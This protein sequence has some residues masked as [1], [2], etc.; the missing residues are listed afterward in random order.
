MQENISDSVKYIGVD[1]TAIELFESQY[2]VPDGMCYNSYVILDEKIAIMDTVDDVA[3]EEWMQNLESAIGTRTPDYVVVSHMEPDHAAGLG[4]LIGKFPAMKVVGN[5]KTFTMI[6]QFFECDLTDRMVVV[7]EGDILDLGEHKLRFVMAP[8]IHWPEV[9]VAYDETDKTLYSADAFGKFGTA[10]SDKDDWICE[11]RRYYF[12]IVGKYGANVQMLLKKLSGVEVK[13]IAPLHG[14]ILRDNIG[15][16]VEMYDLW[17]RYQP[18]DKGV[19]MIAYASIHGNTKAAAYKMQEALLAEGIEEV[20]MFDLTVGD[21][22]F[23]VEDA[24]QCE[25]L[26][27]AAASYDAGLFPPMEHFLHHLKSKNYQGRKV[28]LIEN[29]SWAPSAGKVMR[30]ALEGMKNIE[31]YE[32]TL[33]IKSSYKAADA[34]AMQKIARWFKG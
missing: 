18:E 7:K 1:D 8:M 17:S 13:T 24:F 21:Q 23:M 9:M 6:N 5:A 14:P 33:T 32:D 4:E 15:Y 31:I 12:N 26:V 3:I 29:G 2:T 25:H 10:D 22:S 28:A 34:E 20:K 16:Y 30:A 11:A 27:L 19:V